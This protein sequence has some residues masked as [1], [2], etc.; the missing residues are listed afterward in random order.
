MENTPGKDVFDERGIDKKLNNLLGFDDFEKTFKSKLQKS[1]KRT[2]VGLDILNEGEHHENAGHYIDDIIRDLH[3]IKKLKPSERH[4][5]KKLGQILDITEDI[6]D[7]LKKTEG[8]HFDEKNRCHKCGKKFG[9][10]FAKQGKSAKE[11]LCADC[12]REE[13]E[14]NKNKEEKT[15]WSGRPKKKRL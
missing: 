14:E 10:E 12:L 5:I 11:V 15:E 9:H 13:K 3:I 1:T 4:T 2:D 8:S 6:I 7:S